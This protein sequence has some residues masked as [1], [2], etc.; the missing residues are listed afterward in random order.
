M[1]HGHEEYPSHQHTCHVRN[2]AKCSSTAT[3]YNILVVD[4]E[5][6]QAGNN[7][8][9]KTHVTQYEV[10]VTQLT[11]PSRISR[12]NF[13]RSG[14][15]HIDLFPFLQI[16]RRAWLLLDT[17]VSNSPTQLQTYLAFYL[18]SEFS[19]KL[20]VASFAWPL[21][22][23]CAKQRKIRHKTRSPRITKFWRYSSEKVPSS[24]FSAT[25]EFSSTSRSNNFR[26]LVTRKTP[27]MFA[28]GSSFGTKSNSAR[29]KLFFHETIGLLHEN[30]TKKKLGM[31]WRK[32]LNMI[33]SYFVHS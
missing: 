29:F 8:L 16:C 3:Y 23:L 17:T 4:W 33:C 6:W 24:S 9:H 5:Q 12:Q 30:H 7:I 27:F 10:K 20:V 19:T 31:D 13:N 21:V 25:G 18:I 22:Q 32:D 11:L 2:N 1:R 15:L 26:R 14:I 28:E